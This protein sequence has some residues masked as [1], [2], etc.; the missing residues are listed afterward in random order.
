MKFSKKE[1]KKENDRVI[2]AITYNPKLPSV[3]KIIRKHWVTITKD[4]NMLKVFNKPPMLA[5]KQPPNLRTKLCHAKL[6][7]KANKKLLLHRAMDGKK[8]YFGKC[9]LAV[10]IIAGGC[11]A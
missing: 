2:L 6:P 5:F 3:S 1:P 7:K 4:P 8:F 9:I 10:K 11:H